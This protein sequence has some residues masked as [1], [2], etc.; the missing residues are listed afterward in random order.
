VNLGRLEQL[1]GG[2][3]LG[4]HA[5]RLEALASSC[6]RYKFRNWT[7]PLL[8]RPHRGRH[9]GGNRQDARPRRAG[10][11]VT[12]NRTRSGSGCDAKPMGCR[13]KLGT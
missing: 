11:C 9:L 2:V 8:R 4:V 3:D 1:A 13:R 5:I 12:S 6:P 10:A 7:P